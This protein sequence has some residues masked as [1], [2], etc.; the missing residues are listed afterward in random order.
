MDLAGD[1]HRVQHLAEFLDRAVAN[2][3]GHAGLGVDLHLADMRAV[4]KGDGGRRE[5]A[6]FHQA[7]FLARRNM[8][9]VMRPVRHVGE[10]DG[11]VG[12][13]NAEAVRRTVRCRPRPPPAFRRR[14]ACAFSITLSTASVTADPPMHSA[15]D[16]PL[17]LPLGSRSVS[18]PCQCT[19][20]SGM[21]KRAATSWV[22]AVSSP[23]PTDIEPERRIRLPSS[24]R[25]RVAVSLAGRR[26]GPP[27]TSMQLHSPMPR[28]LPRASR[29]RAAVPGSL[30]IQRAP[31][32]PACS[33]RTRRSRR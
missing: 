31:W 22:N 13:G 12:A 10:G 18:P 15:P 8:V 29:F 17:P 2:D 27:A 1:E 32:L 11:A 28:S 26:N 5:F 9:R 4:G 3:L 16:P 6:G 33:L 30:Q 23:C 14:G 20:S 25:R 19:C 21:P 24:A 7:A